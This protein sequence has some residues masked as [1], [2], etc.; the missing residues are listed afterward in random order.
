L[1]VFAYQ[2]CDEAGNMFS[3]QAEGADP[4]DVADGLRRPGVWILRIAPETEPV[5]PTAILSRR[6]QACDLAFFCRQLAT[7]LISGVTLLAAVETITRQSE[8]P[9]LRQALIEVAVGLR[10]GQPLGE[11]L[12]R[13]PGTFPRHLTSM[14]EMGMEGGVMDSVLTRLTTH[15]EREHSI[16][17]KIKS[18]MIYPLLVLTAALA[19]VVFILV[20][21]LPNF[22]SIFAEAGMALP[23]PTRM[24]MAGSRFLGNFWWLLILMLIPIYFGCRRLMSQAACRL[25][26]DSLRLKIPVIGSVSRKMLVANLCRGLADMMNCGIPLLEALETVN[27]TSANTRL[28]KGMEGVI[29]A[30][31]MGQGL[32]RPMAATGLLPAMVVQMIAIGEESGHLPEL[33]EKAGQFYERE[34]DDVMNRLS[35]LI[36][37]LLIIGVGVI[38]GFMVIAMLLPMFTMMS[39][40]QIQ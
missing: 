13:M 8:Q 23:L 26:W 10:N 3:G 25:A 35:S 16:R 28:V 6:V 34:V 33:L 7:L 1:T 17:E 12:R 21:I 36:E 4:R 29:E 31:T 32:S 39:G 24:V 18:A 38:V 40:T 27:Q 2:V 19:A 37:P 22:T 11:V 9:R 5:G 14:V 15:Y 20:F 30:V